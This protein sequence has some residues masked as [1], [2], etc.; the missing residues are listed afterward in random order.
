MT[1]VSGTNSFGCQSAVPPWNTH[2]TADPAA[3]PGSH[4]NTV[5]P[6]NPSRKSAIEARP[7]SSRPQ[8]ARDRRSDRHADDAGGR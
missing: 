2:D 8:P 4:P 3:T 1:I 7:I 6:A 5:L